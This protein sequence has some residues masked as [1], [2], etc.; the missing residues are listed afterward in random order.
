MFFLSLN[1]NLIWTR[2]NITRIIQDS[3]ERL[4]EL[5]W[6]MV[7][8]TFIIG[9]LTIFFLY[10][11][12]RYVQQFVFGTFNQHPSLH[13]AQIFFGISLVQTP[14][15]NFDLIFDPLEKIILEA[16]QHGHD[17]YH[18]SKFTPSP[19][20]KPFKKGPETLTM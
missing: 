9:Y 1:D 17:Q 8:L 16:H 14:N 18:V 20:A 19:A 13:L 6:T 15:R 7:I 12:P 5:T 3:K 10:Q 2:Y 4:D 11:F